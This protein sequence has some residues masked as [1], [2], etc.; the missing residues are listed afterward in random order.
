MELDRGKQ[1]ELDDKSLFDEYFS[2]Y[3]PETSEFTFTNL[4]IWRK[5]Y[6]LLFIEWNEHLLIFSNT[7]FKK[8]KAPLSN[9]LDAILFFPPIG[10][11]PM[12][13][14]VELFKSKKNIEIHRVPEFLSESLRTIE[15]SAKLNIEI[16]DDRSNWDYVYE[17][18]L[19]INLPGNMYRQNRRW[20]N[21]FL[22]TYDHEFLPLKEE[23]V[24]TVRELQL[25][26][27]EMRECQNEEDLM[28]EQNAIDFA[29]DHF[30]DLN[31]KGGLVCVEGKC[32]AYT[33][34]EMLNKDTMV[35]HIEKGH[36]EYSGAYQ[37]INNAF[38]KYCCEDAVF[39]NREQDL[40]IPGLRRAKE[41]YKPHHMVKKSILYRKV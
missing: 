2:K 28:E 41:S 25:E 24:D 18:D 5:Y 12:K 3:P 11:E 15:E 9:G 13:I 29:L 36:M 16:L 6:N 40:G 32:V 22:E 10:P 20:L 7:F 1:L 14:T 35:I 37:A 21:K 38:L 8:R 31:F 4:F 19:M 27:C 23:T 17:K 34:G 33:F 30:S 26:W 39:V